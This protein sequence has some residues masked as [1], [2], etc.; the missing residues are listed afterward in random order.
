[1]KRMGNEQAHLEA[2][3]TKLLEE[4]YAGL[5]GTSLEGDRQDI[6][7]FLCIGLCGVAEIENV[8]LITK[9]A[10]PEARELLAEMHK[11]QA[12]GAH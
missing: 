2:L 6:C 10:P 1:M 12:K 9:Y 11:L 4:F 5:A 8:E 7:D 3:I